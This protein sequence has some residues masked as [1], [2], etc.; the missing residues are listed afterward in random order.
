MQPEIGVF[1]MCQCHEICYDFFFQLSN[2]PRLLITSFAKS[3]VFAKI[4]KFDNLE[5]AHFGLS[6]ILGM[7]RKRNYFHNHVW[8]VIKFL[9][10][11]DS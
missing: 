2:P 1:L 4:L 5:S 11:F 10:R 6:F 3:F 7:S 8:P 9:G